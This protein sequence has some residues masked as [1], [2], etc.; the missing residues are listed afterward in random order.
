MR[1][2]LPFVALALAALM[3]VQSALVDAGSGAAASTNCSLDLGTTLVEPSD[4]GKTFQ[5]DYYID[6]ATCIFVAS[7]IRELTSDERDAYF[8][9]TAHTGS[10]ESTAGIGSKSVE[11]ES[12][13]VGLLWS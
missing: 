8:A 10:R 7:P 1:F 2:R 13:H 9:R 3:L 4:N 11:S 5:Q 12:L 6:P